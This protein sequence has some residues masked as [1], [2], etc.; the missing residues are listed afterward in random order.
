MTDPT[1][2]QPATRLDLN[3]VRVFVAIHDTRSVTL[4]ADRLGI[5]QPSVS[6]ALSRLRTA[7]GDRLFTRGASGLLATPLCDQLAPPLRDALATVESTIEQARVFD[8]AHSNRRFRIAMSDIGALYFTPPLLRHLQQR[9]PGLRVDIVQPS[10]LLLDD[11]AAGGLD[12]AV[13]NMPELVAKTR[14]E[15][16][17]HERY[18]CLMAQDHPWIGDALS[19]E[20]FARAR[21]V[22]VTSPSSGHALVDGVLT[23]QGIVRN[24]VSSVPQFSVLPFLVPHTD[25]LVILPSRVARL[26]VSQGGLKALDIPVSIPG[27]EVR[28]HWHVRQHDNPAHRWL[29]SEMF[30]TLRRL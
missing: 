3:L 26:F 15:S 1:A 9:A 12:L 25:L 17:F 2:D 16:L 21:H 4:A 29:R 13:G 6:H 22:Q 14:T 5:T 19:V 27:F 28:A 30:E 11:L 20:E 24:V 10:T 23:S 18:M 7:Y 8:P